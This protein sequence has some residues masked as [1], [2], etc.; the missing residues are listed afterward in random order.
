MKSF[1]YQNFNSRS[2]CKDGTNSAFQESIGDAVMLAVMAPQ[3]LQRLG[4]IDDRSVYVYPKRKYD[5]EDI[6]FDEVLLMFQGLSKIPQ[7]PFGYIIDKYR[8][9]I[10][11]GKIKPN[12]YN[13]AFWNYVIMYQGLLPPGE[14]WRGEEYFDAAAKYHIPDNTPY[15]R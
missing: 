15:I 14:V 8:W 4:L 12:Q 7:I 5:T 9:D 13:T 3:H 6:Q 2:N 1:N 10:F 11:S